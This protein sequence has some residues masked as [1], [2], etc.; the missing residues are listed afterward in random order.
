MCGIAGSLIWD[1]S[2]NNELKNL[3]KII[4]FLNHRGPNFN[5][6]K[7]LDNL[8]F[9]HTRLAIIDLN[10]KANQ[11]MLD[12]SER[13]CIVYNGEIYNFIEIKKI[14]LSKGV[15]FRT[16]SDT[17]VVLEAYKFWGVN[18][19]EF[20]EGMFAVAIWDKRNEKLFLARDRIGEKP[21][22]Y[23]PYDGKN[24]KSGIIFSSELRALLKHPNVKFDI[25]DQAIWEFLSLNYILGNSSM[26]KGVKKLEPAHFI[27]I[28]KN[29]FHKEKYWDLKKY[30]INKKQYK[31]KNDAL[32]EFKELLDQ[33]VKKQKIS[34]VKLGAFL[35]GGI[36]SST[37]VASMCK[38]DKQDQV[39]AFC[40]GFKEKN[41]SEVEQSKYLSNFFNIKNFSLNISSEIK[42][43]FLKILDLTND[44]PLGDT[45]I[46]PMYYL[47]KFT[48]KMS[49][50]R[51]LVMVLMNYLWAMKLI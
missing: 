43:D 13:F 20:F 21:L 11:P 50:F 47:T 23:Y 45:S 7:K 44:E 14:L 15:K 10:E 26:I 33:T 6:V 9:G 17:E 36:D 37:I 30:F 38:S 46:L 25:S 22:F 32:E 48:K 19:L 29:N 16:N 4:S 27:L 40:V 2:Q 39:N 51:Y 3:K 31:S 24:F 8:V 18:C 49:Q 28:E 41:Y 5:K 12:D 34:D 42:K 1:K 35:S